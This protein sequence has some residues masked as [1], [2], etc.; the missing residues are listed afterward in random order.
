MLS[1]AFPDES[2]R[3]LLGTMS[4]ADGEDRLPRDTTVRMGTALSRRTGLVRPH[5][6]FS[7]ETL[8]VG[9]RFEATLRHDDLTPAEEEALQNACRILTHFGGSGARGLGQCSYQ[10]QEAQP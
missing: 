10:F 3:W 1:D 7:T 6:L 4:E 8:P 2:L 5:L 9:M